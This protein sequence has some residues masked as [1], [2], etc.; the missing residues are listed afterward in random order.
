MKALSVGGSDD[1]VHILLSLPSTI[2]IAEAM[3]IIKSESSHWVHEEYEQKNFDW[4]EG[5]GAFS[6]GSS[7]REATVAYIASQQEHHKR[8]DFTAEFLAFLKKNN[9]QYDQRYVWG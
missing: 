6:I 2:T 9:I 3:R 7:Q 8:R 1:H 5:Y 4:Q